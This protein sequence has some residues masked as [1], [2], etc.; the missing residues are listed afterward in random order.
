MLECASYDYRTPH[1]EFKKNETRWQELNC[2]SL[3]NGY[4][5]E[6]L[7]ITDYPIY[8][9]GTD[10]G[11]TSHMFQFDLIWRWARAFNRSIIAFNYISPRH[12]GYRIVSVCDIF[13]LPNTFRCERIL[14]R[15]QVLNDS[16][17][18]IVGKPGEWST[19][20]QL[21][22]LESSVP[23]CRGI[24]IRQIKCFA[25]Y[26]EYN[27]TLPKSKSIYPSVKE[28]LYENFIFTDRYNSLF[29]K[30]TRILNITIQNT[31]VFH[32]RRG[33]QLTAYNRCVQGYDSSVN[34]KSEDSLIEL[35]GNISA[36]MNTGSGTLQTYISTNELNSGIIG[37]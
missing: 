25:G 2:T 24:N 9:L 34:C 22:S 4:N 32:W 6:L 20:H 27:W 16:D 10:E 7:M 28:S 37:K 29:R 12:F 33:D 8:Y 5:Q 11:F 23:T 35:I 19:R 26:L 21:Y 15:K 3:R 13:V 30:T 17:C 36:N 31:I 1:G 14:K 18:V